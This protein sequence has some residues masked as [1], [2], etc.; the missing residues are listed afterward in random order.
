[1][2]S[3]YIN[4][5]IELTN[6]ERREAGLE[7]LEWD[8]ELSEA[9]QNHS[10][11]MASDDFFSHKTPEGASPF[12]RMEDAGYE[13]SVAGENIA[14]G[15]QTPE[16]VVEAWMGSSSHRENILNPDFTEIGIG[17]E[18]IANDTGDVS[19][20]QYWSQDFGTPVE[21][22]S[23]ANPEGDET[24]VKSNNHTSFV[25]EVI[26]L[27][28][29][30]RREAG[31]EPL[32][33]D[34]ELSEAA[35]NHSESMASDDFFSHKTPE[36]A[37]PFERME[38]AGYEYSVAGENIAAGFQTPEAVVEAWMGS[39]SHRENILNPDFTEIGIGYESIAN[40]TGDVSYNQYW[41]QDFGTPA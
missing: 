36:G 23:S 19:Y 4:E 9:A 15:F 27:T 35:Q 5:V 40:D 37:S 29:D 2:S 22:S 7:P 11:S 32:E 41:S 17:Y 26:E 33:W 1:M 24:A 25:K 14:A 38:D 30:E 3:D 8:A 20:N 10:E 12:E 13:Y 39:S 16:A 34:A 21:G 28:N 6:D 18:S 31:L